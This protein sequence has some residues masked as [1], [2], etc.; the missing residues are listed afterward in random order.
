[1]RNC[2]SCWTVSRLSLIRKITVLKSLVASQVIYLLSP[3]QI[4]CNSQ[5]VKQ[6]NDLF[7]DFLWNSKGD[8]I[9][10]NVIIQNYGYTVEAHYRHKPDQYL[11]NNSNFR[12]ILVI[13]MLFVSSCCFFS[14]GR[15]ARFSVLL[16][17][18]IN[19]TKEKT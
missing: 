16:F 4:T 1:M 9:K 19:A 5:I 7:F 2:L 18:F 11:T 15:L 10:R 12:V 14:E 3:F 8:K 17:K 6:I 13:H